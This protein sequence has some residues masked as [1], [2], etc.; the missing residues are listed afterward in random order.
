MSENQNPYEPG[1]KR[2]EDFSSY[3]DYQNYTIIPKID[4][5]AA[6][7]IGLAGGFFLYQIIGSLITALLLGFDIENAP[8]NGVRIMTMAGQILF[9]LLPALILT[10]WI[11]GDV[12][13]IIRF[14]LPDIK[15][16]LLFV[17]GIIILTPLLQQ[18]L[19]IQEFFIQYLA[20]RS[21]LIET[22]K[23]TLD[24]WYQLVEK[25]LMNLLTAETFFDGLL[26]ILVIAIVPAICEEVLFRGYIQR[27]FEYRMKPFY[28]ALIT[29]LFFGL[30]HMNPYGIVPL[31][32]LG[33]YFGFAAYTSNSIFIPMILHFLNNFTAVILFFMFGDKEL[34][35]SAGG[36]D[37][38]LTSSL[39]GFFIL[40]FVFIVIIILIKK[41]YKEKRK[42]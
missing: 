1:E 28:A 29:A 8:V 24:S 6:A 16:I 32:V 33:L 3:I 18:Y 15:E 26:I 34:I 20:E 42:L 30:F 9:M 11:Y 21:I 38:N 36:G 5:I 31:V 25:T 17:I 7:F 23:S 39:I 12:T 13:A 4:P 41:Y 22:L 27:S 35:S 2:E 14:N 40:L 37:I 19:H 10:Q